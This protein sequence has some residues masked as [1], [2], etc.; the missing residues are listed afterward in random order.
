MKHTL[1]WVGN[2]V[3]EPP[4]FY[5]LND[6]EYFLMKFEVDV[7]ENHILPTLDIYLKATLARGWCTHKNKINKWFQCKRLLHIR[8]CAE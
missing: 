6:L 1:R 2:E 3:R 5:G 7:M 4:T 8:F